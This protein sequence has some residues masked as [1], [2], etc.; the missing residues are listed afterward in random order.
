MAEPS[1]SRAQLARRWSLARG[2][3]L[4]LVKRLPDESR[5]ILLAVPVD[6]EPDRDLEDR[7]PRLRGQARGR[8]TDPPAAQRARERRGERGELDQLALL[9]F[10]VRGNDG[11][12]LPGAFG[13]LEED[14]RLPRWRWLSRRS[15]LRNPERATALTRCSAGVAAPEQNLALVREVPKNVRSVS[16]A[17]G[18]LRHRVEPALDV[19]LHG[20]LLQ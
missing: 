12:T 3:G 11:L 1:N 2:H 16:P 10:W 5:Q 9:K 19:E 6:P 8:F 14:I 20:R 17:R 18:D 15:A 4:Q 7:D 13:F